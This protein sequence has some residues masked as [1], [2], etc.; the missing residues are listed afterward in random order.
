MKSKGRGD[1]DFIRSGSERRN[2]DF[3]RGSKMTTE[4]P[5]VVF[6]HACG[7]EFYSTL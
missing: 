3:R 2:S 7:S 4:P 5:D 1:S 6:L